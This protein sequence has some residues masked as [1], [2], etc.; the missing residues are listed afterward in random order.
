ML[1]NEMI[2]CYFFFIYMNGIYDV[3]YCLSCVLFIDFGRNFEFN[4][5]IVVLKMVVLV[6]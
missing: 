5:K 2:F 1:I 6:L 4:N 3:F